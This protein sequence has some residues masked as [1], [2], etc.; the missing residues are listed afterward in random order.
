MTWKLRTCLTF[1][2]LLALVV[3]GLL[4]FVDGDDERSPDGLRPDPDDVLFPR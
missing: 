1:C 4:L 2:A 3:L